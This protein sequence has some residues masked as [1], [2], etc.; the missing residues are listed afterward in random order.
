[1]L[2]AVTQRWRER[3]GL[4]RPAGEPIRPADYE[5]SEI[6]EAVARAFVL[7]HH[8]SRSYP[9]ARFRFGLFCHGELVG[10]AVYSVPFQKA[11]LEV[12]GGPERVELGRFVLV[13]AV[14]SNGES[15]FL[16]RTFERVRRR[17]AAV[18]SFSDP[19]AREAA[20]G[21]RVFAGHIGTVYQASNAAYLGLGPR[22]TWRLFADGSV[23]SARGIQKIRAGER[24]WRS[25][26]EELVKRGAAEP[27][28]DRLE[29]LHEWLPR[30]KRTFRHGGCHRYAWTFGRAELPHLPYPKWSAS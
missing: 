13:D 30:L 16:A 27:G 9:A 21:S 4:Y 20:D 2:T 29:W 23:F 15:W 19:C 24:G 12:P 17:A 3:R 10:A 14:P 25:A 22:R 18:L 6:D 5:V 26:A 7:R 8:Y 1:M 11:M 28:G